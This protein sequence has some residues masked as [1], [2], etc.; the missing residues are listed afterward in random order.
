[1]VRRSGRAALGIAASDDNH[2]S[3]GVVEEVKAEHPEIV[4]REE[5]QEEQNAA[6][7][8]KEQL[9]ARVSHFDS[10]LVTTWRGKQFGASCS[11]SKR[12]IGGFCMNIERN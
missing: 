10:T 3:Q 7:E 9:V 11:S 8:M 5:T 1:M 12:Q 4:D 6:E 2:E